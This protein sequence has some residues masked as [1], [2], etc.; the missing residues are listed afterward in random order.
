MNSSDGAENAQN[1]ELFS[2]EKQNWFFFV[3]TRRSDAEE[4]LS[5]KLKMVFRAENNAGISP[6]KF[7]IL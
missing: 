1:S 7:R 2:A 6:K 5:A 4:G 3:G